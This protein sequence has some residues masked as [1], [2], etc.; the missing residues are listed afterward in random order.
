MVLD[1]GGGTIDASTY[2]TVDDQPLR[3]SEAIVS[4]AGKSSLLFREVFADR[5]R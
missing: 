4:P 5:R 3:L 2:T 1:C